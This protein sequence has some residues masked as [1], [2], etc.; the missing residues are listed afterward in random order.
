[1]AEE[2]KIVI[3]EFLKRFIDEI[4]VTDPSMMSVP[5]KDEK[6]DKFLI[7]IGDDIFLK[8][9][10][11]LSLAY[12]REA[13]QIGVQLNYEPDNK[14]KETEGSRLNE[15]ASLLRDLFWLLARDKYNLW[16]QTSLGIRTGWKIV[17]SHDKRPEISD[18]LKKLFGQ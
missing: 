16:N 4:E 10:F 5:H 8:K 13:E 1:M 18:M 17:E 3:D 12:K 2:N 14:E 7:S 11:I 6:G 15:R 9:V